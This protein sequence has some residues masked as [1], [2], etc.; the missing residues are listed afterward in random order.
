MFIRTP[1]I[2]RV[3]VQLASRVK[4]D[5]WNVDISKV[6]MGL[7][8]QDVLRQ[9]G[10][11]GEGFD[12]IVAMVKHTQI[13]FDVVLNLGVFHHRHDAI[14]AFSK[15]AGLAQHVLIVET[16]LD[17]RNIDVPAIAFYPGRELNNDPTNWWG[18]NEHCMKALLVGHGFTDIEVTAHPAAHNRAIFHAWRSKE[19]RIK[20]LAEE[21]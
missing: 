9:A 6:Q 12:G 11:L 3:V 16:H 1:P 21:K 2:S 18:T 5:G 20:P 14:E 19:A 4:G 7:D 15:V 10:D 13:E 17:L 8:D